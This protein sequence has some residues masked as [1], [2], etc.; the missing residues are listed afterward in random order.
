MR[1]LF[2][3]VAGCDAFV[4][5]GSSGMGREAFV[6]PASGTIFLAGVHWFRFL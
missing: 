1:Q 5:S 2:Q 6:S 3:M 4:D